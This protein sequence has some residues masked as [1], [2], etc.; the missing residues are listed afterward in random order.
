MCKQAKH[1]KAKFEA[2]RETIKEQE[3][4]NSLSPEEQEKEL[5]EQ[6]RR[7]KRVRNAVCTLGAMTSLFNG[8]YN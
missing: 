4:W 2:E 5:E 3:R 7:S 1:N 6:K 8:N